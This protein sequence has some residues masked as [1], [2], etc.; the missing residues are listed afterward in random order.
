ANFTEQGLR[1][2]ARMV[3][4]WRAFVAAAG[5]GDSQEHVGQASAPASSAHAGAH[6]FARAMSDDLNVAGAIGSINQWINATTKPT[7]ADA[8]LLRTFDR[9]LGVLELR[10]VDSPAAADDAAEIES[11]I[12]QRAEARRSKDFAK[13]DEIR[14]QLAAIGVEI[15]DG[16]Q[17][18]TWTRRASL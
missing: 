1:D 16:P 18:T 6:D 12:A 4:R 8:A 15:K 13:S 14:D 5:D 11:L 3:E 9:A 2:S 17:G 10:G 7:P